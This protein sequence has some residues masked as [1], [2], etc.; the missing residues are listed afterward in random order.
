MKKLSK[1]DESVWGGMLDRSTGDTVRKEDDITN[2]KFLKPIDMGGSVLWAD[3]DL[4]IGDDYLFTFH[5]AFELIKNSEWRLPTL[6]EVAELD[7][8]EVEIIDH[9]GADLYYEY[10]IYGPSKTL[11]FNG[12]GLYYSDKVNIVTD[13]DYYF[14]WTSDLYNNHQVHIITFDDDKLIH[15]KID[16]TSIMDQVTNDIS[17]KLCVRLVKDK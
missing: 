16:S 17:G 1:I 3:E 2:I 9:D 5:E 12:R 8:F 4:K 14:A 7:N 11:N 6:K 13:T 10:I 15:S